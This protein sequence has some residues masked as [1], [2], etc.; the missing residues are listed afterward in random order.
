MLSRMER[1]LE[2]AREWRD[3]V[4]TYFRRKTGIADKEGRK[5]YP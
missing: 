4:N 5:I 3:V 2:N 1:Q